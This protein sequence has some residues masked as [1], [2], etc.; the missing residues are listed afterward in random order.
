M[1][2]IIQIFIH[3]ICPPTLFQITEPMRCTVINWLTKVNKELKF[4]SETLFLAV[5][6]FDRFLSAAPIASD[7]LQLLAMVALFVASKMVG[8]LSILE[9][10][11]FEC[12]VWE[13]LHQL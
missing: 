5:N 12:K 10:I 7:C 4:C 8:L 6:L 9:Y 13:L 1:Y 11:L 2:N 3:N